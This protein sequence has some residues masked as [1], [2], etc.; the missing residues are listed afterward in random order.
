M[1]HCLFYLLLYG[2][3]LGLLAAG[4]ASQFVSTSFTNR[5]VIAHFTAALT[6]G[7]PV[8][9]F[10][11]WSL[12][13]ILSENWTRCIAQESVLESP[14]WLKRSQQVRAREYCFRSCLN[15]L[16][17]CLAAYCSSWDS[18]ASDGC[19][20]ANC[21]CSRCLNLPLKMRMDAVRFLG[22][23]TS[24]VGHEKML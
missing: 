12:V 1:R 6:S 18:F 5:K 3:L 14:E 7:R 19:L 22:L 16:H 10:L 21:S 13:N 20:S 17:H 8:F 11:G 9:G 24:R 4:Y 15:F 23:K 2:V